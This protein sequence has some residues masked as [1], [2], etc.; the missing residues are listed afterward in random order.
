MRTWNRKL[1]GEVQD[2]FVQ[3]DLEKGTIKELLESKKSLELEI[4]V[5]SQRVREEVDAKL[6]VEENIKKIS[7]KIQQIQ[8]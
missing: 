1:V 6:A 2:A 8:T 7:Y 4:E 5:W 3:I